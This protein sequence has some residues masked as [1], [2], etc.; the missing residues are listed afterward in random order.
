MDLFTELNRGGTTMTIVTHEDEV[1][2]Y[3]SRAILL[4]DGAVVSDAPRRA[5]VPETRG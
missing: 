5:P 1:A 3:C 4:R 2:D